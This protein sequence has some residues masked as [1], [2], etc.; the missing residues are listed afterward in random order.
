MQHHTPSSRP[1]WLQ[2]HTYRHRHITPAHHHIELLPCKVWKLT[3]CSRPHSGTSHT[4]TAP[5][6]STHR[7]IAL[8]GNEAGCST[9]HPDIITGQS[10][11]KVWKLWS[12][13]GV[14][15]PSLWYQSHT[16]RPRHTTPPSYHRGRPL[17]SSHT[18]TAPGTPP[19]R[20]TT[21][22][23]HWHFSSTFVLLYDDLL[24]PHR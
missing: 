11:C 21:E 8:Q 3:R 17:A 10:P 24:T 22:G 6:T 9:T 7:V 20:V 23:G 5:G 2:S 1:H 18:H 19:H 13:A 16:Y 4:H 12:G 15:P 14:Q